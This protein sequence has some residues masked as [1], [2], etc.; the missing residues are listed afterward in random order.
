[1]GID[2]VI[3]G[4][5][6]TVNYLSDVDS[7]L[8]RSDLGT[9]TAVQSGNVK[10]KKSVIWQIDGIPDKYKVPDL[11]MKINPSNL[12]SNYSQLINRKRTLG[13]F[14]EEHWG[15]QLD[16]ISASGKTGQFVNKLGLTNFTRRDTAAY[17]DFQNLIAIYRNNGV[18]YDSFTNRIIAQG[19]VV[20]NYDSNIYKGYFENFTITESADK[21]FEL[22][23]DFS[24]KVTQEVYPGR[25]KSF[26]SVTTVSRVGELR[27]DR[28]TLDITNASSGVA[29]D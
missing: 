20:M 21:P 13:G 7:R 28:V 22:N 14:I 23:Y 15:E 3:S 19:S 17:N 8:Q 2:K 18:L 6:N 10:N 29:N 16:S 11:I 25:M 24:F 27:N 5:Q 1:M 12:S 26:R 4:L 9:Y